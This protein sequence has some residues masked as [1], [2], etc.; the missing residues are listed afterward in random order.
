M[1]TK[2]PYNRGDSDELF[3]EYTPDPRYCVGNY[4]TVLSC[5]KG[6]GTYHQFWHILALDLNWVYPKVKLDK[7]WNLHDLVLFVWVGPKPQGLVTCHFPDSNPL[8]CRLDN[9]RY[10]TRK[11]NE[12]HKLSQGSK[13]LGEDHY[14][15][16]L[17]ES[18]VLEIKELLNQSVPCWQIAEQFGVSRWAIHCIKQNRSWSWLNK[19]SKD[20]RIE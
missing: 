4:G 1:K 15:S 17:K 20:A 8:N 19:E 7:K 11:E 5:V 14:C 12:E 2:I 10:G 16:K 3:K 6:R 9:L 18:E 13:I